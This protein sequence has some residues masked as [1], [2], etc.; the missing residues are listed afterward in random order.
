VRVLVVEDSERLRR[1]VA[2]ALRRSGYAVDE[3]ADGE[4]GLHHALSGAYDVVVLD[5]MLPRLDGLTVLRR[6]RRA[7]GRTGV[8]IL[9][10]RDAVQDRVEG[11]TAG[12]DDY[13]VKPFALEE[14][15]ARVQAV[16]RRA[17]GTAAGTVVRAGA[18]EVDT[19]ARVVRRD[20]RVVELSAREYALLEFLAL[21]KGAVVSRAEIEERLYAEVQEVMSNVVDSAVCALRRK[22]DPPDRP[23]FIRTRRGMGY[24][25]GEEP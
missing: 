9:T 13:L 14:L 7:G 12:A 25:L 6:I 20:G 17:L 3:A 4:A 19:G 5:L 18:L 24:V 15:L 23:S 10:A 11:L 8:L 21:R 16:G 22:I 2:E 1:S